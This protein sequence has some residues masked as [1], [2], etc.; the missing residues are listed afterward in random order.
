MG[1]FCHSIHG[2]VVAAAAA[3]KP[4]RKIRDEREKREE[5]CDFHK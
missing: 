5:S 2:D 3:G 1:F 4:N